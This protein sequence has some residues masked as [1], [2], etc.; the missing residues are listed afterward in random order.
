MYHI[1]SSVYSSPADH[2]LA[3]R[4]TRLTDA[5]ADMGEG[6]VYDSAGAL[7]VFHEKHLKFV[8][9]VHGVLSH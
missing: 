9:A 8:E 4:Y 1:V 5:F 3:R 6:L 7:V 2:A